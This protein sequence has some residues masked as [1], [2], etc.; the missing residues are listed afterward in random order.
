M[1]KRTSLSVMRAEV[2]FVFG[3]RT[4]DQCN[5]GARCT[6]PEESTDF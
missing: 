3:K 4:D 2:N 1:L 5:K 6:D